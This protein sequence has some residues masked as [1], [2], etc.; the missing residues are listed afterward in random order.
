MGSFSGRLQRADPIQ[1][2][3]AGLGVVVALVLA[4]YGL[5]VATA[6]A[7]P[8]GVV[9]ALALAAIAGAGLLYA[10]RLGAGGSVE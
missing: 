1:L 2:A 10:W 5:G 8:E 6:A 9:S 4:A 7:T 3:S